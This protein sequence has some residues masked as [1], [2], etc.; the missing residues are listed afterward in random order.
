MANQKPDNRF[1]AMTEWDAL[2]GL[3]A[4]VSCGTCC[5]ALP[6]TRALFGG[7]NCCSLLLIVTLK[8][9]TRASGSLLHDPYCLDRAPVPPHAC[10]C[11]R[12][13]IENRVVKFEQRA[14]GRPLLASQ[15]SVQAAA[16]EK[17]APSLSAPCPHVTKHTVCHVQ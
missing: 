2:R 1:S 15:Q 13:R 9:A 12:A 7:I 8:R 5:S 14:S 10:A 17:G 4:G 6:L 16:A 11:V 3:R